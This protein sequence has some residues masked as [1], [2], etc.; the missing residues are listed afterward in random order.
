MLEHCG[1]PM[2]RDHASMK[3]WKEGRK[4]M[5]YGLSL[6]EQTIGDAL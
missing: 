3:L 1:L 6:H 2:Q 5:N 4:F